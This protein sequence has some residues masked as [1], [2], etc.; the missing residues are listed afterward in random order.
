MP[1]ASVRSRRLSS[2]AVLATYLSAWGVGALALLPSMSGCSSEA[3][4]AAPASALASLA[5]HAADRSGATPIA[6][7]SY[8][9]T[10]SL[11]PMIAAVGPAVV[12]VEAKGVRKAGGIGQGTGSGFVIASNGLVV[13]NHHVVDGAGQVQVRMDDGGVYPAEVLG[14]DPATDL[15]LLQLS[16]ASKLPRVTLGE[17]AELSVGDW[18]VAVGNPMGLDHSASVGIISGKGRGSLGLY[19][20]SYIDF[21]QTDADIAPGSSG[22]PLFDLQGHVVGINTAVG[23]GNGPGFAIP[24]DQAKRVI[25]QLR[26]RGE[27]SRGWLGAASTRGPDGSAG[28]KLGEVYA[29]TPAHRAG[30]RAG[31]LITHIEGEQIHNFN[32]LR[33]RIATTPPGTK[34]ELTVVRDGEEIAVQ[35]DL[36]ER[37]HKDGLERLEVAK[38]APRP[39]APAPAPP[40]RS[41]G[42]DKDHP[43]DFLFTPFDPSGD[44]GPPTSLG[45]GARERSDGL[46]VVKVNPGSV[47]E[48]LGLRPG[49]VVLQI[50]GTSVT[51]A[52]DVRS[53]LAA[54]TSHLSVAYRRDGARHEVTLEGS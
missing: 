15:A 41:G 36:V 13:T 17:S 5:A 32:E 12:S 16:G 2:P 51:S 43:L 38:D 42:R 20:D 3:E 47:A 6:P 28:A 37:P 18:V 40:G 19:R 9:P 26:D 7:A 31:D 25:E 33:G 27:V 50:N 23:A 46:E 52:T 22:G 10:K 29:D 24:I 54:T 8:D 4:A 39:L 11:A 53:A 44:A 48:S 49:D 14:T 34:L 45:I 1:R 35:V 30:L 21:L